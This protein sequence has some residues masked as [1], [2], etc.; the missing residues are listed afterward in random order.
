MRIPCSWLRE[1]NGVLPNPGELIELLLM[2]GL[3]VEESV[4][5]SSGFHKVVSARVISVGPRLGEGHNQVAVADGGPLGSFRLVCGAPNLV[6]DEVVALAL[7]GAR[8]PQKIIEVREFQGM[9]SEGMLCSR[10]ELG[11]EKDLLPLGE[12]G[13]AILPQETPLGVE[14]NDLLGLP[15]T[16]L[17]VKVTANRP[18]WN[19]VFG[20][21]RE[22]ASFTGEPLLTLADF[23]FQEDPAPASSLVDVE[24]QDATLC[25]RYI[26]TVICDLMIR[27]SPLWLASRLW[28]CGMR[29]ISNVVDAT[30]YIMLETGQP[31][32]G[33][34]LDQVAEQRIIVRRAHHGET[35]VTLDGINR[36]L[37]ESMLLIADPAKPIGI[38]GVMG[39]LDSEVT[40]QTRRLV[41][42]SAQFLSASIRRTGRSL[43]LRSEASQRFERGVSH[44]TVEQGSAR[45]TRLL[46]HL[47]RGRVLTGSVDRGEKTVLQRLCLRPERVNQVLAMDLS[48]KEIRTRLRQLGFAAEGESSLE[49]VVPP[50]R[51]D[52]REEVDLVEDIARVL[53]YDRIPVH[54]LCGS[55]RLGQEP[56]WRRKWPE[57]RSFLLNRG[58]NEIVT[59]PLVPPGW[60][61]WTFLYAGH[62]PIMLRNPLSPE[63]STLRL[64]IVPSLL[65]VLA[66]N[67]HRGHRIYGCFEL[68]KTYLWR[69]EHELPEEPRL[70]GIAL[71]SSIRR[72]WQKHEEEVSFFQLK[73]WLEALFVGES[74]QF[75]SIPHQHSLNPGRSTAVF[76][77]GLLVG[78]LG[79]ISPALRKSFDL[80]ERILVAEVAVESFLGLHMPC[81]RPY[82]R[83]PSAERDLAVVVPDGSLYAQWEEI[84][85]RE[86]GPLLEQLTFFDRYQGEP[87]P[88]GTVS[89]AF[90][91]R[92]RHMERTLTETEIQAILD[93]IEHALAERGAVLRRH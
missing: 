4:T 31:L 57:W 55:L 41:L 81:F 80:H 7:P 30:N 44:Y 21:A 68:A 82:S 67:Q 61:A 43:G 52:V 86:S 15:D 16:V 66:Q 50:W 74:L 51:Q 2:A 72:D 45:A 59:A 87:L 56:T 77:E 73:G 32:H 27:P 46:A 11:L 53:G 63:R 14:L 62:T 12:D 22:I 1:I 40:G 6:A 49:V 39:G 90:S 85:R 76:R 34:D 19:S 69:G 24:I 37:D 20:L 54:M 42:E 36:S 48:A 13:I 58:L 3:E 79:E 65:Q 75:L 88:P 84:L 89:L 78:V 70:L 83:F 71:P 18:D 9:I 93:R 92:F 29:P 47:G 17:D 28:K 23:P 60:A 26:A 25:S 35:L 8:L 10:A 64:S 38:A 5:L 33:F 91:L